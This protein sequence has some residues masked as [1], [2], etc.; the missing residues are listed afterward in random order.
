VTVED[1]RVGGSS[2]LLEIS[3][4][5]V[6]IYKEIFGRGPGLA[7]TFWAG[8]DTLTVLLEQTLT[9]AERSLVAMGEHQ[10]LRDTRLLFQ[11]GSM[12]AF[13]GAIERITG[14]K[15]R[16]FISGIDTHVE[17]LSI[18]TFVLHPP[19]YDGPSRVELGKG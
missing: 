5:M 3:N 19:G 1:Q 11:Y 2:M 10:A 14:R 6:G 12:D 7:R 4:A 17:G 13:C 16:A 18:E 8:P 15:V 9:P